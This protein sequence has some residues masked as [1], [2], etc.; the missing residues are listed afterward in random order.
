MGISGNDDR[1]STEGRS[2]M[3][4]DFTRFEIDLADDG[5]AT[6]TMTRPPVNAVD[7]AMYREIWSLF[8]DIDQI[9]KG[10][11][12]VVLTGAGKHFCA[13]N[14]LDDFASMDSDNVRERMYH[15]R[16]AFFAIQDCAVPVVGAVAG[17]ALGTGLCLA[18]ACDFVLASPDA[19]FGL[20]E[21]SVGVH[22][23]GVT[24][25]VWSVNQWRDGC[26]SLGNGFPQNECMRLVPSSTS[27]LATN[28]SMPLESRLVGSPPTA[29]LPFD[30]GS[31][32]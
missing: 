24:S 31:R 23:G 27:Y 14:D 7:L 13:G 18:A 21:L 16:E 4:R 28:S 30:S 5:V 12:A 25:G 11:R 17:A 8:V 3:G 10:V 1:T 22:G 2:A 9:G 32:D 26:S 20:P 19:V 6:V 15:V 29:R